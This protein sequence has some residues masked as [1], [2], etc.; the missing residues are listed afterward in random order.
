MFMTK[1]RSFQNHG[2]TSILISAPSNKAVQEVASRFLKLLQRDKGKNLNIPVVL[3]GVEE[4][5][6]EEL[7][8]TILWEALAVD[9]D[10]LKN[11]AGKNI[12]LALQLLPG[13][14]RK[15]NAKKDTG[16]E[17]HPDKAKMKVASHSFFSCAQCSSRRLQ[18]CL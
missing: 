15:R 12:D 4:K 10:R 3:V 7:K 14:N 1:N 11:R 13:R 8:A 17:D 18:G 2:R 5:V 16:E 6:S 9:L